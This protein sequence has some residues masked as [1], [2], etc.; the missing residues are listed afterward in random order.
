MKRNRLLPVMVIFFLSLGV[1]RGEQLTNGNLESFSS[2][3]PTGWT[4]EP[5]GVG[6]ATIEGFQNSPFTNV[7]PA[8]GHSIFLTNAPT[9]SPS[10][11]LFQ[12]FTGFSGNFSISFEFEL[13]GTLHGDAWDVLPLSTSGL[14]PF[15]LFINRNGEFAATDGLTINNLLTLTANK[16][17]QVTIIGSTSTKLYG[18]TIMEYGDGLTSWNN[19]SFIQS[20]PVL[21]GISIDNDN[22]TNNVYN[23]PIL[24]DNFSVGAAPEPASTALLLLGLAGIGL[25][26]I[27]NWKKATAAK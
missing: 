5:N 20:I 27:R 16:W 12:N 4:Y 11:E 6:P 2:G 19:Y 26:Q 18:G 8:G 13:S 22:A 3:L 14:V 23:T 1:L 17:Y 10:P 9:V 25:Y 21:S 15:D 24:F 7:Y